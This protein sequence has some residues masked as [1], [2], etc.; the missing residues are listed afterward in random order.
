LL[1]AC[2]SSQDIVDAI[3]IVVFGEKRDALRANARKMVDE[4]FSSDRNYSDFIASVLAIG[5]A[6]EESSKRN[7]ERFEMAPTRV[8]REGT[9]RERKIVKL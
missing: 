9:N 2:P 8:T 3:G 1:R 6:K 4:H 7:R 5:A